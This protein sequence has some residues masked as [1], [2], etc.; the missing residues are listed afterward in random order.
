M[1]RFVSL[2]RNDTGERWRIVVDH[3]EGWGPGSHMDAP[4]FVEYAGRPLP[5]RETPEEL[6]ALLGQEE[7][8]MGP[9]A[10]AARGLSRA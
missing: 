9:I 1:P 10:A 8:E 3:V 7:S 6:D 5:V 2:T 4:G